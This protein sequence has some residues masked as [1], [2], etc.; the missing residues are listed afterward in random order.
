MWYILFSSTMTLRHVHEV[1]HCVTLILLLRLARHNF[2]LGHRILRP[3]FLVNV[4]VLHDMSDIAWWFHSA[5][6]A[7]GSAPGWSGYLALFIPAFISVSS[8]EYLGRMAPKTPI[9]PW[10][11]CC[12]ARACTTGS[13]HFTLHFTGRCSFYVG[14]FWSAALCRRWREHVAVT[15]V[16]HPLRK[17]LKKL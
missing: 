13:R 11:L 17:L 6:V 9:N 14:P 10:A 8:S 7:L 4:F 2:F 1:A 15:P 3:F 16:L 5:L 12:F